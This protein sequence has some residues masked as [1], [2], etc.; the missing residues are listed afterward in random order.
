MNDIAITIS[1]AIREGKWLSITYQ[2]PEG[3]TYFLVAITSIIDIEKKKLGVKIYNESKDIRLL[4]DTSIYFDKIGDALLL[5]GTTYDVPSLLIDFIEK[6]INKLDWLCYGQNQSNILNYLIECAKYDKEP[7]QKQFAL[8][9]GIDVDE[10]NRKGVYK[11]T[12]SQVDKLL[13]NLK[14]YS[15][16][17]R[18][19]HFTNF[20]ELII[21]LLSISTNKGLFVIAYKKVLL[22]PE[23]DSLVIGKEVHFN[24]EFLVN[25]N[26][27]YS[28]SMYFDEDLNEFITQYVSNPKKYHSILVKKLRKGEEIDERPYL[29]ELQRSIPINYEKEF[30]GIINMEEEHKLTTPLKAF[31]GRN[32]LRN[33]GRK[34]GNIVLIDEKVNIDQLR[35]IHNALKNPVTYVQGPPGTGKTQTI[36]NI[37]ISA[38]FNDITVL[39]TSN[40][41]KPI[42]GIYKKVR[43]LKY[44]GNVIPFPIIR[45]GNYKVVNESLEEIKSLFEKY[46]DQRIF[47]DY[48]KKQKI[49][50]TEDYAELNKLL[51]DYEEKLQV[52]YNLEALEKVYQIIKD[53]MRSILIQ[54][55]AEQL[56]KRFKELSNIKDEDA[57]NLLK[58]DNHSLLKWLYYTSIKR[59]Q[60]LKE[61]K[62]ESLMKIIYSSSEDRVKQFNKYLSI[63]DNLKM[64]L[65]VFPI[66]ATTN[67][68]S[69][70]LGSSKPHF[71]LTIMDEAGQCAITN[72]LLPIIRGERLVLVGDQNQLEPVIVLDDKINQQLMDKYDIKEDYNYINNSILRLMQTVD[73]ISKFILLRYHYRSH[74]KIIRFSGIKYY[75]NKLIVETENK[76]LNDDALTLVPIKSIP[77]LDNRNTSIEEIDAIIEVIKRKKIKNCGVITPFRNQAEL[78]RERF[79]EKEIDVEVGTIHTFQGDENDVI[80]LTTA[81]TSKTPEK[82]FDWVKNNRELINVATTRAK[83]R[84]IIV[85]DYDEIKKRSKEDNDLN[86]LVDYIKTNGKNNIRINVDELYCNQVRGFKNYNSKYEADFLQTVSHYLT[87]NKKYEIKDKVKVSSILTSDD[88]KDMNYYLTSEF[89]F[90]LFEKG[91]QKP[92]LAIE[93]NG[94]EH[95]TNEKVRK[96]DKKKL[97][98]CNIK[99]LKLISI[100]NSYARRYEYIK[101][102]IKKVLKSY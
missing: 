94:L 7:Y 22:N 98:I 57:L 67:L 45:L 35:V 78:A 56:R 101:N 61:P 53:N 59:I 13:R 74:K 20:N 40:N 48:L 42:D 96:R 95:I 83:E 6:N 80:F 77:N 89:D 62:Y 8:I 66:V 102:V 86:D 100:P 44:N 43:K 10:L 97:E 76:Y 41:N 29:M 92:V 64:F 90:V 2:Q 46:K 17:Y 27:K 34:E 72:S 47:S 30:N 23:I 38:F 18:D 5:E 19:N 37:V 25:E 55:E 31:F 84:L 93:L 12:L 65:R 32:S 4:N 9:D 82:T 50:R 14:N 3:L 71:D 52:E 49:L 21:N 28:L 60:R 63:D 85:C 11:L 54:D 81:I 68:S 91:T 16:V 79:K 24:R 70:H 1:R 73:H 69:V 58:Q 88:I 15:R 39:I 51:N 26:I 36:I 87:I 33:E 99:N 75:D